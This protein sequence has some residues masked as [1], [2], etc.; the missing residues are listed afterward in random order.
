MIARELLGTAQV[1]D[2]E[3]LKLFSHGRDFMIVLGRNE[4]MSTRMR[5]SE[6]QLAELTLARLEKADPHLL[7]GGYG[8]GFT[9]R[10][11]ECW[12]SGRPRATRPSPGGSRRPASRSRKSRSAPGPTIRARATRSGSRGAPDALGWPH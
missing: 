6:E 12:P 9:P 8:M 11:A 10:P 2:G 5:H 1:P 7:V 4:L 3:E